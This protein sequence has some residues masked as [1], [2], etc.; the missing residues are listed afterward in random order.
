MAFDL[1]GHGLSDGKRGHI[2]SYDAV[3]DDIA[4]FLGQ[5]TLRF[6]DL[7]QILYG[8]SLGGNLV[9]NYILRR[10]HS[11]AAALITGPWFRLAFEPPPEK[12]SL[13]QMMARIAPGFTQP[14]GLDVTGL[15]RDVCVVQAYTSDPLVHN[16]ISAGSFV[17]FHAAG[18]W[19][20]EHAPE[21]RLPTLLLHGGADRLTSPQASREFAERAGAIV[22][23]H[24]LEGL[25]HEIHNE[26]EQEQ[27]LAVMLDGLKA[28]VN[29]NG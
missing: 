5:V 17:A 24:I 15:S 10:E 6:A 21:W 25:Y 12:I 26:P 18:Y 11:L 28:L 1:R 14:S 19:A 9:A 8:H 27:V 29:V 2:P 20:L 3:M 22:N 13:A 7:P 16:K 23:L 4:D